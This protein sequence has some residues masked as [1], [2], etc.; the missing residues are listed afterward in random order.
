[1]FRVTEPKKHKLP[2]PQTLQWIDDGS[3]PPEED[4][5]LVAINYRGIITWRIVYY[6]FLWFWLSDDEVVAWAKVPEYTPNA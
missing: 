6:S 2:E 5:Y 1:M 4:H 3:N